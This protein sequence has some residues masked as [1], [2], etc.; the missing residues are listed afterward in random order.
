MTYEE[1]KEKVDN[2]NISTKVE[3]CTGG[4]SGGSC[5]D[6]SNPSAYSSD[7]TKPDNNALTEILEKL[8]PDIS[9]IKVIKIL[10]HPELYIRD[11]RT[12]YQYYGNRDDY[13][14][15]ELNLKV[16]YEILYE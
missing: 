13:E 16:L 2:L 11:T 1:F 15:E 14:T 3:W 10:K 5:W 8:F 12:D 9:G 4:V 6:S 7:E